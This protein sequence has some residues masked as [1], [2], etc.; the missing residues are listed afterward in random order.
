MSGRT[1]P[2][3]ALRRRPGWRSRSARPCRPAAR[4]APAAARPSGPRTCGARSALTSC[5]V[6]SCSRSELER[7]ARDLLAQPRVGR[8]ALLL[9][10]AQLAL[11]ALQR[12]RHRVEQLADRLGAGR[13]VA[14]GLRRERRRR[15][16]DPALGERDELL[17]VAGQRVGRQRLERLLQ[18]GVAAGE[19]LLPLRARLPLAA[20]RRACAAAASD[21]ARRSRSRAGRAARPARRAAATQAGPLGAQPGGVGPQHRGGVGRRLRRLGG[22]EPGPGRHE[23]TTRRPRRARRRRSRR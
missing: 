7:I 21:S 9:D 12:G 11:D 22:R 10:G 14:V 3:L 4:S 1:P 6:S 19:Q 15:L 20:Q 18:L 17:V 23:R 2:V 8:L 16:L 13:G 5:L